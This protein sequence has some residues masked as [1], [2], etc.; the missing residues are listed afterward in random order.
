M[1][2]A[3]IKRIMPHSTEAEQSVIGSMLMDNEAIMTVSEILVKDDFYQQQYGV[4]YETMIELY[5]HGTPVDL[6]T[7]HTRLGEKD[8][9]KDMYSLEFINDIIRA[10][11]TSA[12][13]KHYA[14]IVAEKALLRRLIRD[15]EDIS[16]KC[17]QDKENTS[18]LLD[19]TEKKVFKLLQKRTG[20]GYESMRD[21]VIKT[22]DAIEAAS[23][24]RGSVTGVS[25]GFIE[26][27]YKTAGLQPS[28]LVLVAARPA[29][30]KTA[31]ALNIAEHAILKSKVPTVYFS[32]EM[33]KQQMASRLLS[34]NSRVESQLMRTG[35]LKDKDWSDLMESAR[36][37]SDS[38]LIIDDT[39]AISIAELRSKCRR[40]K[41]EHGLGLII[42]DYLQLMTAGKATESR[43]NE[44][45]EISR[46]LKAL[47][48]E[49]NV[50][51]L[52]LSQLSRAV[53]SRTDKRPMLSD[54]RE[55]GAIEQD[56][57][58][59]MFIYR[60][61]YYNPDSNAKG[62]A[63][64]II[65]KQRNGPTGT[66][67]LNYQPEYTRFTNYIKT[68]EAVPSVSE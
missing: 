61:E 28:D 22:L 2:E 52:A 41:L 47:A 34:M 57:D 29:M 11:P 45:S 31:F 7:L 25:T 64:I 44:V 49:L 43:Q 3:S 13:A 60:D 50:P 23:K 14:E 63:E 20:S 51:V 32:L 56:A 16:S 18:D 40:Y 62:L 30:G 37:L 5:N 39:G 15:M 54:L 1:D 24:N 67:T 55:S 19:E 10:V 27:D 17:Y 4:L 12:H 36:L 68:N 59:V 33:S 35:N 8:I 48:R 65:G 53:E 26:L 58:V 9:P 42:I 21:V 6:V 66:I 38:Q 46:S